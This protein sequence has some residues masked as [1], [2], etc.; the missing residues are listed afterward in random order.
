VADQVQ[1]G[2]DYGYWFEATVVRWQ[3]FVPTFENLTAISIFAQKEG[4]PGDLVAQIR[5]M[6]GAVLGTRVIPGV[7]VPS[8]NWLRIAFPNAINLIPGTKYRIYVYSTADSPSPDQ[9]FFWRGSGVS[10]YGYEHDCY[11]DVSSPTCTPG[12]CYPGYDF[13]FVTF[14]IPDMPTYT[15]SGRVADGDGDPVPGVQVIAGIQHTTTTGTGG[16]FSFTGLLTGSYSVTPTFAGCLF[17]P[18][19]R[20]AS[21][22]P[23]ATGQDFQARCEFDISGLVVDGSNNPFA[24]VEISSS[25]GHVAT[26]DDT[27]RYVVTGVPSG[28]YSI[29]PSL[30]GYVFWP[31]ER[32]VAVPPDAPG[33]NFVIVPG[34]VS[35]TLPISGTTNLPA[36]LVYTDTQGLPTKIEF[37]AGALSDTTRATN[38]TGSEVGA[39]SVVLTPFLA[40]GGMDLAF[41][42][43]AFHLEAHVDGE[44]QPS[45]RLAKP[46]TITLH[47]SDADLRA[48]SDTNQLALWRWVDG[49]WH[50][51]SDTCDPPPAMNHDLT[52]QVLEVPVCQLG[53][54]ALLGPTHKAYLALIL[55]G[56]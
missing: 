45:L 48:V 16:E 43:H 44:P 51:A 1:P 36:T 39:A 9:R 7:N 50:D 27:G 23:D 26:S 13:A 24:G 25:A 31:A 37:P 21:V 18:P 32:G 20:A 33:R 38:L 22:P 4:D 3:E 49:A 8:Y 52:S 5:T 56:W 12:T 41:A 6:G 53:R 15:I 42:G 19:V 47:Y 29:T 40:S 30:E 54:F 2:I 34:P 46:A 10:T 14:G 11:S 55:R 17:T 35:I 28:T